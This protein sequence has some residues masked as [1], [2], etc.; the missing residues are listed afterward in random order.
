L[1][2]YGEAACKI[3]NAGTSMETSRMVYK[4]ISSIQQISILGIEFNRDLPAYF[5]D[6]KEV[7]QR[8]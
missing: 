5:G 6:S 1:W 2:G 4:S 8:T 7:T 3:N